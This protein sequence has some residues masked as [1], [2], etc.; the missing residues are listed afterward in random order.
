MLL[1]DQYQFVPWLFIDTIRADD[2]PEDKA[3]NAPQKSVINEEKNRTGNVESKT[4]PI[5]L[6]TNTGGRF[7]LNLI[8]TVGHAD[9]ITTNVYAFMRTKTT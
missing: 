1:L 6:T 5:P 2:K 4:V 9:S 7:V 3:V 8:R